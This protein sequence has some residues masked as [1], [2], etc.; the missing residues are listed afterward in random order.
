MKKTTVTL[1]LLLITGLEFC[2]LSSDIIKNNNNLELFG[3]IR[4]NGVNIRMAANKLSNKV[5]SGNQGEVVR[6]LEQSPLEEEIQNSNEH[7]YKV[8]RNNGDEGW[9][10]GNYLLIYSQKPRSQIQYLEQFRT[11]SKKE[12]IESIGN[13]KYSILGP[14]SNTN[15]YIVSLKDGLLYSEK[16]VVFEFH[17]ENQYSA[18]DLTQNK[19]L[20]IFQSLN[21]AKVINSNHCIMVFYDDNVALFDK[22]NPKDTGLSSWPGSRY[23]ESD[24]LSAALFSFNEKE[25]LIE[26][27]PLDTNKRKKKYKIKSCKFVQTTQ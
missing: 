9:I 14:K 22:A 23:P 4:G 26:A 10:F 8:K 15:S 19:P 20:L 25:S 21:P 13:G 11:P 7:W 1:S 16:N 18:Y 17:S 27:D 3:I 12:T 2:V 24:K 5:G 6:V